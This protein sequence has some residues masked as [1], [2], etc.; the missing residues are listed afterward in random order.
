VDGRGRG[1]FARRPIAGGEAIL[2]ECALAAV[3][4]EEWSSAVCHQCFRQVA[5]LNGCAKCK[6]VGWCSS[7]CANAGGHSHARRGGS[8]CECD[9][10]ARLDTAILNE[11]DV[12]LAKLF[13]K[14]L[15][16]RAVESEASGAEDGVV[17]KSLDLLESNEDAMSEDRRSDLAMIAEVVLDA[18]PSPGHIEQELL[19]GYMCAEQCNSFGIWGESGKGKGKL[20]GFGIFP[21][22]CMFNHRYCTVTC[23]C[24]VRGSRR[25]PCHCCALSCISV[26]CPSKSRY[27]F[28][29][30]HSL[31]LSCTYP[32]HEK[33]STE[34]VDTL[35]TTNFF[36]A[37]P[38]MT[39]GTTLGA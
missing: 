35:A 17:D 10:L 14:L 37:A 32:D 28:C 36:R 13:V 8:C 29:P 21:R 1:V 27:H 6:Q 30:L 2:S 9:A 5:R 25:H 31:P 11:G 15:C 4:L 34:T 39:R 26:T 3:V 38:C 12:A 7:E 16:R 18:V 20:L 23:G 24:L 19:E 22:L 33:T